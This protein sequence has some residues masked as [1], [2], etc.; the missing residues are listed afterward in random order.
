MPEHA[1]HERVGRVLEGLDRAVLG[2][3]AANPE[4]VS[5]LLYAL[6][7]VRFDRRPLGPG[8]VGCERAELE[9]HLVVGICAGGVA[10]L[11]VAKELGQVVLYTSAGDDV[12]GLPP[13]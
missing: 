9:A 5:D 6:V 7:V 11:L 10:V 12:E 4:P 13:P 2:G 1:E 8:G 3:P